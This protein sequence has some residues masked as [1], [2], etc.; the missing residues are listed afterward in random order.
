MKR[1]ILSIYIKVNKKMVKELSPYINKKSKVLDFGCGRGFL[2]SLVNKNLGAQVTGIDIIDSRKTKL[3]FV[4]FDGKKIPFPDNYFD[5]VLVSYVLH[6]TLNIKALLLEI[7]RVC[8]GKVIIYEDTPENFIHRIFCWL[9]GRLFNSF[10]RV[11]TSCRFLSK[12]SWS[13]LFRKIQLKSLYTKNIK[14][15]NPIYITKR[16]LFVLK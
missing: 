3:P 9:H 13:C 10:F 7:K 11:P 12:A 2:G 15:F 5:V 4:L 16:T 14:F 1:I 8:R 6:H